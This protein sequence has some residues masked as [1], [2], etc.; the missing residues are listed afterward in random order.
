M[1]SILTVMLCTGCLLIA[2]VGCT[3]TVSE[4]TPTTTTTTHSTTVHSSSAT[5]Y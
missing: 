4:P 1:K 3:T 5:G 2:V